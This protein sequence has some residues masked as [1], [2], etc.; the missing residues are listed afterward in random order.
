MLNR[1]LNRAVQIL[2]GN[3]LPGISIAWWKWNHNAHHPRAT[4]STLT[5]IFN[6]WHRKCL[7]DGAT[8]VRRRCNNDGGRMGRRVVA[9]FSKK[10]KGRRCAV[11]WFGV[12]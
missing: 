1:H 9:G 3:V 8:M 10:K 2:S 4:A 12:F 5:Q 11:E 7:F 6:T